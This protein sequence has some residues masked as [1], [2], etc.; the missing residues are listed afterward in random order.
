M[1]RYLV[2]FP[3][4]LAHLIVA[5]ATSLVDCIGPVLLLLQDYYADVDAKNDSEQTA[6]SLIAHT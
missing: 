6:H 4:R 2:L 5:I 3:S 1:R